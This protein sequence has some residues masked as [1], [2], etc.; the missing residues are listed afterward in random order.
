[1]GKGTKTTLFEGGIKTV[2]TSAV[3]R[4]TSKLP[5]LGLNKWFPGSGGGGGNKEFY[6]G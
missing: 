6:L 2:G 4:D 5:H 3:E 1:M